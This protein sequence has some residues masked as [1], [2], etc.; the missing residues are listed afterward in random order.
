MR[1]LWHTGG[2]ALGKNR[3][4]KKKKNARGPLKARGPG[5]VAYATFATRLIRYC[6][7]V[8]SVAIFPVLYIRI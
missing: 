4:A 3:Q 2:G 5:P 1:G 6:L 7:G 8:L